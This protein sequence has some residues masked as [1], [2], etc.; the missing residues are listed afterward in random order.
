MKAHYMLLAALLS[1]ALTPA[2][3]GCTDA[4]GARHALEAQGF[5]DIVIGDYAPFACAKGD[6]YA[7]QFTATNPHGKRVSG[8]VCSGFLKGSTVRW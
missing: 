6:D 1:C 4:N 3:V 2:L 8:V 7:T 5:T